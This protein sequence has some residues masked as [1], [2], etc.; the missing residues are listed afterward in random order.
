MTCDPHKLINFSPNC[1]K[2]VIINANGVS[3]PIEGVGTISLSPSSI[4]NVLFI[5]TLNCNLLSISKLT[6]SHSC[7]ALFYLTHCFFQNIH[8]K[9]NIESGRGRERLYY[10]E[11]VSQQTHKGMLACLA[12]EHIQDKNKKKIWLWHRR[13]GHPSFGYLKKI[14][15]SLFHKCNISDFIFE[16]CV[17]EKSHRAVFPLSNKK[18]DFSFSLIH[19]DVWGLASQSTHNG[20]EWFINFVDDYTRVTWMYLLKHKSNVCNV[21]RSFHHMIVTQFNTHIKVIRSDN[22]G[23]YFKTELIEFM[24]SKGILHQTTCP[25]SP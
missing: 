24:N 5:P 16:T 13:L 11:N 12:N 1:S 21:F 15:P 10:L 14:F 3:S 6:K 20:K 9:E 8:S 23:E 19:T 2:T 7:V 18:T 17:M 25:Y 22:G 4:F